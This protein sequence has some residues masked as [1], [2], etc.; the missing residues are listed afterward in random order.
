MPQ[1]TGGIRA[2]A[3]RAERSGKASRNTYTTHT[4]RDR[5]RQGDQAFKA[6]LGYPRVS[7]MQTKIKANGVWRPSSQSS[8]RSTR[9]GPGVGAHSASSGRSG[10]GRGPR[11]LRWREVGTGC[12]VIGAQQDNSPFSGTPGPHAPDRMCPGRHNET[13]RAAGTVGRFLN[14][15]LVGTAASFRTS[16][17]AFAHLSRWGPERERGVWSLTLSPDQSD[18]WG[19]RKQVQGGDP[20]VLRPDCEALSH[21]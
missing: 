2:G 13:A 18:S 8:W 1:T 12:S 3:Q 19:S 14:S 16:V 9:K 5:H 6:S 11:R 17:C 4:G 15:R 7:H 10:A 21:C 20:R